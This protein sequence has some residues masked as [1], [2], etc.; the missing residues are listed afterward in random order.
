MRK[1]IALVVVGLVVA[2]IVGAQQ[3]EIEHLTNYMDGNWIVAGLIRNNGDSA[4]QFVSVELQGEDADGNLV[5]TDTTYAFSPV[6]PG[7]S[8]PFVF[9]NGADR[10]TGIKRYS[11]RL[12]DY[13]SG[14]TGSFLFEFETFRV[15]ERNSSFHTWSSRITNAGDEQRRFVQVAFIGFDED[16]ELVC[17]DTTYPNSSTL[18]AGGR[19][20]VD[21]LINPTLSRR[22]STYRVLAFSDN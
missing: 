12:A 3:F 9:V 16:G 5:M 19:S 10:A 7:L 2:G 18:P 17:V 21:F 1:V 11:V 4:V 8:I 6:P 22:I 13:S 14:G 20:V 15:T